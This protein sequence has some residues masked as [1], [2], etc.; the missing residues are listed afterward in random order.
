VEK[1]GTGRVIGDSGTKNE[2]TCID[3]EDDTVS[4]TD[5]CF[6]YGDRGEKKQVGK[7]RTVKKKDVTKRSSS[8]VDARG[9]RPTRGVKHS[10]GGEKNGRG[11]GE[12]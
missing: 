12:N 3:N 1:K 2:K 8:Q 10:K 11:G 7:K 4:G 5:P 9:T 6:L